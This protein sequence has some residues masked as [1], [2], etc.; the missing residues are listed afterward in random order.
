MSVCGKFVGIGLFGVFGLASLSGVTV[1]PDN[2]RMS[3]VLSNAID[4]TGVYPSGVT[5]FLRS[6]FQDSESRTLLILANDDPSLHAKLSD[7]GGITREISKGFHV[8][9][10]PV[11]AIRYLSNW[12]SIVYLERSM[13]AR[14]MLNTSRPAILADIVQE[15]TAT[16]LS[17]IPYT[18]VG[19]YVGA[20]D[21]GLYSPHRDFEEIGHPFLSRIDAL[22]GYPG[23]PSGSD[24]DGHGTHVMG[25]A[26]GNGFSS[27][28]LYTG[29]APG[30]R[31]L[32][33]T[34]D[35]ETADI[36]SGI[37]QILTAAGSSPVV[38]NLS[39]GLMAG[40]HDGT[41]LFESQINAF[42]NGPAAAKRLIAVAAGNEG[43]LD[44]HFHAI[45]PTLG[46]STTVTVALPSSIDQTWAIDFW[47]S[48][49]GDIARKNEHDEYRVTIDG[50]TF[51]FSVGDKTTLN[52][53]G[54]KISNRVDNAPNGATH[55]SIIPSATLRNSTITI[56]FTRTWAGGNGVLDGYLDSVWDGALYTGSFTPST[57][58][59]SIIEPANGD[60]VI[61]VGAWVTR[62][63]PDYWGPNTT[64]AQFS[65][66]G[67]TRD[68]RIKPDITAP[69][70]N[71]YS[72]RSRGAAFNP[73]Y[74]VASNDN[75]AIMS[76]TS[77]ATPHI[78][79]IAALVW[80]SNPTLTGAQM[81]ERIRLAGDT[82]PP[83]NNSW[84]YGKA[85]ALKAITS[86]VSA[87]TP[88]GS[89]LTGL[90]LALDSINSSGAFGAP[91]LFDWSLTSRPLGSNAILAGNSPT[92]SFTPD[93]PGDYT[94]SLTVSQTNPTGVAPATATRSIH[95]NRIPTLPVITGPTT[96]ATNN[97]VSFS[98]SSSDPD[99]GPLAWQ[100]LV[101][102]RPSGSHASI[103]GTGDNVIFTPDITGNYV[104]G[105]RSDDGTDRSLLAL[106]SYASGGA[107]PIP[108]PPSSPPASSA[109]SAGGGCG[110]PTHPKA[111][112]AQ[113]T[114]WLLL[115]AIAFIPFSR[116][117]FRSKS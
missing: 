75:Y 97:P 22:L 79:G 67:P 93:K 59:G 9:R 13:I 39:L 85:N 71:I 82:A 2:S 80:E 117:F 11:E 47:G 48:G 1:L 26:A 83:P 104:V 110:I 46:G 91:L 54:L 35:Y 16:G 62:T 56:T 89:G 7:L 17:G 27:R 52:R 49:S 33:Y 100:W 65:S 78:T 90:P 101:V 20:V 81:R 34:T 60:N 37:E 74:L 21:T 53:D 102:S 30:A 113:D 105:V 72:T 70:A 107:T 87:I 31:I 76:G 40:S 29:I 95:A 88:T 69:G 41:S 44:E 114:A 108:I 15:G 77:V 68:G 4:E 5:G 92:A 12:P 10:V 111:L 45:V 116:R 63:F 36:L 66:L 25:V 23:F 19:S 8:G 55:I 64:L 57:A 14:R 115:T 32:S 42:A 50:G 84:G 43:D 109:S 112:T 3:P 99:G 24:G 106:H 51:S 103:S 98:A 18:G 38:L 58:D 94:V 73:E 28:G 61:S 96:S 86:A 6:I